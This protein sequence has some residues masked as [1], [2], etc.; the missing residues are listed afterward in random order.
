MKKQLFLLLLLMQT[1][2][3]TAQY[4]FYKSYTGGTNTSFNAAKQ[5]ETY[6]E[7]TVASFQ[8]LA[9]V[10]KQ[11]N[12]NWS[13]QVYLDST[14]ANYPAFPVRYTELIPTP[15]GGFIGLA[16][17][18]LLGIATRFD[19]LGNE[20]WSKSFDRPNE[21]VSFVGGIRTSSDEYLLTTRSYQL[22]QN[23][24]PFEWIKIDIN[25]N[26]I[27]QHEYFIPFNGFFPTI[28]KENAL[29][30][31]IG[32]MDGKVAQI[33]FG[34]NL[35]WI[36]Q[37]NMILDDIFPVGNNE[38]IVLGAAMGYTDYVWSRVTNT[39]TTVWSKVLPGIASWGI[40]IFH[41]IE[42]FQQLSDGHIID[43]K[44]TPSLTMPN[45]SDIGITKLNTQTGNAMWRKRYLPNMPVSGVAYVRDF[46]VI[47][48]SIFSLFASSNFQQNQNQYGHYMRI[49]IGYD[50]NP[51][52]CLT[53][54]MP[55][56]STANVTI[57]QLPIQTLAQSPSYIIQDTTLFIVDVPLT[58]NVVCENGVAANFVVDD[59]LLC[60]NDCIVITDSSSGTITSYE[61]TFFGTDTTYHFTDNPPLLCYPDTGT[62]SIQLVVSD[63][64]I[65]DT[66]RK[67]IT[68]FDLPP[69]SL[70]NDTTLCQ[71]EFIV[72]N[73]SIPYADF[74]WNTGATTP[75]FFINGSGTYSVEVTAGNCY[76]ADTFSVV[77]AP[78]PNIRLENDTTFCNQNTY[79]IIPNTS[80]NVRFLWN[81]ND[82]TANILID[83]SGIYTLTVTDTITNCQ[84]NDSVIINLHQ[85]PNIDLGS[86]T[87]ICQGDSIL[88]DVFTP[89]ATYLWNNNS[90]D[91]TLVV[92]HSGTY[93]VEVTIDNCTTS[94]TINIIVADLP[95]VDLGND[96]TLC[97]QTAFLL[98]A[99]TTSD[100]HYSWNTNDTVSSIYIINTGIYT[101]TIMDKVTNCQATDSIEISI[102][103][104]NIFDLG[105]D[106]I[107]CDTQSLVL[108]AFVLDADYLWNNGSTSSEILVNNSGVYS[109]TVSIEDCVS[110]DTIRV[111]FITPSIVN[112]GEDR[113]FC[114]G[115]I[116]DLNVFDEYAAAY[117]WQDNSTN[118]SF[119]VEE[120]G[121]YFVNVVYN[122]NCQ[123]SDTIYFES[124][125]MITP[126]LPNDTVICQDNS[127]LLNAYQPNATSYE[128]Q[129]VEA[130][131]QQHNL[132][133]SA[134][135]A[136]LAGE[137][138][139][140]I[141]NECR[142]FTQTITIEEEDCGC[143][144]YIPNAF[145]PNNDGNN[146][147]F[148]VYSSCFLEN[149]NLKIFDRWGGILFETTDRNEGWNGITQGQELKNG[150]YVWVLTYDATNARGEVSNSV[151]SGTV[152]LLR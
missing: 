18:I 35:T 34:G 124:E 60:V 139:V 49:D 134:I 10:N 129:A 52:G 122:E 127:I 150:V 11:G 82:T 85:N 123:L 126:T 4:D 142:A 51:T 118:S 44:A 13:K 74:S 15:D 99:N 111:D 40:S 138:K 67:T 72:P 32:S 71:G 107:L 144:P 104:T 6:N 70:G 78:N 141:S 68:V 87:I 29:G 76:E 30:Y 140:T 121:T 59:F 79:T 53:Q 38:Y 91:S 128:W 48:D 50:A 116:V 37:H 57:T 105:N 42:A 90:T 148:E 3:V 55:L 102:F 135:I 94:D 133:D 7:N 143:Y 41:E 58:A 101:V 46:T 27:W 5:L 24:T 31:L 110:K 119:R 109:V 23:T 117:L 112:L 65:S 147:V 115:E 22:P 98:I 146:D 63:G 86:D 151:K 73:F 97:N 2:W 114:D 16:N 12:I 54:N 43:I 75:F 106:T 120:A 28:I 56:T 33:D 17:T 77:I 149:Y 100:A 96:T 81:T 69:I 125:G 14:A 132:Q 25:G 21:G 45:I 47:T 9:S 20:I 145:T 39:G 92:N 137:Y 136:T 93:S 84:S 83:T 62:F 131:Y 130:Y 61:W 66:I 64:F 89:N 88:L 1:H 152:T 8:I 95:T 108:D 26:V 19:S 80:N 36:R 103:R 113:V